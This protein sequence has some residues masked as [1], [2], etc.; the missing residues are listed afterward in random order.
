VVVIV[1]D[2]GFLPKNKISLATL[3]IEAG[4]GYQGIK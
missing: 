3:V 4:E 1:K 2:M